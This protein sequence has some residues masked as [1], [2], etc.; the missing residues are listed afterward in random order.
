MSY[1]IG[2]TEVTNLF[3]PKSSGISTAE[4][5]RYIEEQIYTLPGVEHPESRFTI[6]LTGSRAT[7]TYSD[8]SDV[9]INVL[10]PQPA[11]EKVHAAALQAGIVKTPKSFFAIVPKTDWQRYFGAEK[12]RPHFALTSL[13]QAKG[14]FAEYRDVWL[15]VWT[16]AKI[17]T[18]PNGQFQNI[19]NA[20]HGYPKTVLVQ[21]LKYH[22]LLAGYYSIDVYPLSSEKDDTLLPA[23]MGL[24]STAMELLKVC[25]LVEGNPFPYAEKLMR[26]ALYTELG[27]KI[28]PTIQKA[29]ELILG[30]VEGEKELWRRLNDAFDL[31][32]S[33]DVSEEHRRMFDACC[34]AMRSA[35]VD[36]DWVE[37]DYDNID[38]LLLGELGPI[39]D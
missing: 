9:D 6:L 11:Y 26:L 18:D 31:L 1:Q 37:A 12:H 17:I 5:Q 8:G 19:A 33:Y 7:G 32:N 34:K 39:P 4:I 13:E 35:G 10:C 20:F 29:V 14:H 23:A 28:V 38:E 36:P 2:L 21:K 16:T 3:N 27:K 22:W 25:F 30:K 24:T 15:W